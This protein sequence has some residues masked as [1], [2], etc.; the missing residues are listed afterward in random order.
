MTSQILSFDKSSASLKNEM[1]IKM[2]K[3]YKQRVLALWNSCAMRRIK[4][5]IALLLWLADVGTDA[6]V[7]YD[8][9]NRCHYWF[10]AGVFTFMAM[11]G[12]IFGLGL[13]FGALPHP[14]C[15]LKGAFLCIFGPL[16]VLTLGPFVF[17][18]YTA[19]I[20]WEHFIKIDYG[21]LCDATE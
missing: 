8:L 11:P 9:I 3:N 15:S 17:L 21:T 13:L 7:G 12:I 6:L 10:A 19:W 16:L 4:A 14:C 1:C 20:L 18:L 2:S 5:N